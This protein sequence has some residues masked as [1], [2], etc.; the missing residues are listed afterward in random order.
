VR[1]AGLQ[2]AMAVKGREP[3]L[4]LVVEVEEVFGH[5][6][7]CAVRSGLWDPERWPDLSDVPSLAETMVAH[8]RLSEIGV[9]VAAM[10][11]IIDRDGRERLY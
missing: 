7:K 5:C 3:T 11:D 4:L 6:P 2:R 1:D 10:Q 8:G 9:D